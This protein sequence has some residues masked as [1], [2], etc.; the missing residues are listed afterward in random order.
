MALI[1]IEIP[2]WR[3][4]LIY[5]N[6]NSGK[7]YFAGWL[8]EQAYEQGRRFIV[9]DTKVKNH[10]GLV[11]LP[12]VKLIKIKK[13]YRYNWRKVL[14]YDQVLV[15][16]TKGTIKAIG[17][18]GLVEHYYKPLLREIN[19]SDKDRI[20]VLEEAHHYCISSRRPDKEIE[21]IFREGRGQRLYPIAITQSI[22]DFPKLLFRQA[23]RHFIFMHHVPND[24]FYLSKMIPNFEELNAQLREHDLI[25]YIPPNK[26]RIIRREY[27]IRRTKHY[28]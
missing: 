15:I 5:G 4:D 2:E 8:I 16:P 18:E 1:D 14:E 13:G 26:T 22:A 3:I 10:V 25:E 7:S 20:V 19:N 23:K 24:K 9:L 28:G 17:V 27:I 21:F 12:N 11:Q 6:T